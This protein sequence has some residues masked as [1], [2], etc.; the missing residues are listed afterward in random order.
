MIKKYLKGIVTMKRFILVM[1][2][3]TLLFLIVFS[4]LGFLLGYYL[5]FGILEILFGR[6]FVGEFLMII[7]PIFSF[8]IYIIFFDYD[9][10]MVPISKFRFHKPKIHYLDHSQSKSIGDM[11]D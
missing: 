10:P 8:L 4:M 6:Y 2:F 9:E 1:I 11:D 3:F 7:S 5:S